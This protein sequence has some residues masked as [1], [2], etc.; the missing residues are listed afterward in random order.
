MSAQIR[1]YGAVPYD[2]GAKARWLLTEM[3][4]PFEMRW[5]NTKESEH[6]KPEYLKIHPMGRFP[7]MQ[8][9]D[10]T[11]FESGAL[12]AYLADQFIE[13]GL[14]PSL[15]SPDRAHY[16]QWMYFAAST[17]DPVVSR[18][19]II[20]DI[21]AGEL[22]TN[23]ETALLTELKDAVRAVD[24]TVAKSE[25]LV[26]NR[27]SAADI[28]VSYHFYWVSLWPELQAVVDQFP[29]VVSYLDRLKKR[30]SAIEAKVFSYES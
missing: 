2:R 20:E 13:K 22:R 21:P 6:E 27:F 25:Y 15:S 12:C 11:L 17:L 23:K 3:G 29:K 26:G 9:G 19:M 1:I 24:Q 8:V 4:V 18:I 7:A 16:Q 10:T 28:C 30:P 5:I 14:A